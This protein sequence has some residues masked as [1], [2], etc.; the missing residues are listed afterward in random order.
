MGSKCRIFTIDFCFYCSGDTILCCRST[1]RF[2]LENAVIE[3]GLTRFQPQRRVR[4][5]HQSGIELCPGHFTEVSL[6]AKPSTTPRNS[7][8][9]WKCGEPQLA[10]H[11][12][13]TCPASKLIEKA[14][15]SG[16]VA[17]SSRLMLCQNQ[18]LV[19]PMRPDGISI[20]L[21]ESKSEPTLLESITP[22]SGYRNS[23]M[24][25]HD[26]SSGTI[27]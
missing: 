20:L 27:Q 5:I 15:R 18:A 1:T 2:G 6:L 25:N 3:T 24:L 7:K 19:R 4:L 11:R 17:S 23:T 12:K 14:C 22:L 8:P 26:L 13:A 21:P 10:I 16:S 9:R